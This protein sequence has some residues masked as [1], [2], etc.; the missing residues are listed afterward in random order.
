MSRTDE[1][2]AGYLDDSLTDQQ[3]VELQQWLHS[4]PAN[5]KRFTTAMVRDEQLRA[6]VASTESLS[7]AERYHA[8]QTKTQ[9]RTLRKHSI[10]KLT[11]A[12]SLVIVIAWFGMFRPH[13]GSLTFA[14]TDGL[15]SLRDDSAT[16][17]RLNPGET[18]ASGSLIVE[19]DGTQAKFSYSDGSVLWLSG[20]TELTLT[21]GQGKTLRLQA[22]MLRADVPPQPVDRPLTIR[23]SNAQ[24]T[25]F[26][27]SFALIAA[28]QET[29]L[30]VNEGAVNFQRLSD[31]QTLTVNANE[32]VCVG[33]DDTE[34][35]RAESTPNVSATWN[36]KSKAEGN[37]TL[38]GQWNDQEN[39]VA[40][41]ESVFLAVTGTNEIHYRAGTR[42]CYPG[43]VTLNENSVVRIRYRLEKP[44]NLGLFISTHLPSWEFSGN[45][46]V[47]IETPKLP[48]D[49]DGWRTATVPIRSL[50]PM[51]EIPFQPGCVV[52]TLFATSFA[53][54]VGLEI[55]E[56][57]VRVAASQ[58]D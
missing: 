53:S 16:V 18:F 2:I 8:V 33:Q 27:T 5:L 43:L 13:N 40:T 7:A 10:L 41:P 6:A 4:D 29:R 11:V 28:K 48:A 31:A 17:H 52:S 34:P 30:V 44:V 35:V 39:L 50:I 49:N 1:L 56:F 21:G 54:D 46:R 20:G 22:G 25:A 32:Q 3:A 15:V 47:Y 36:V 55:A 45:F 24:A 26:G 23:T 14:E 58:H 42:N 9:E 19:G 38:V 51:K 37:A 57:E 12:T